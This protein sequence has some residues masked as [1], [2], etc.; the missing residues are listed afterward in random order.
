MDVWLPLN[1]P[2][3]GDWDYLTQNYSGAGKRC[4]VG[5]NGHDGFI[6]HLCSSRVCFNFNIPWWGK[7]VTCHHRGV[8]TAASHLQLSSFHPKEDICVKSGVSSPQQGKAGRRK[9]V[10]RYSKKTQSAQGMH[11]KHRAK[12]QP[13]CVILLQSK[14]E[15]FAEPCITT[16]KYFLKSSWK[17][18]CS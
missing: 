10:I 14:S 17:M 4:S 15:V 6:F 7:V 8:H 11:Q 2:C 3:N 9:E 18:R 5:N 1:Q 16:Y 12:D 13:G